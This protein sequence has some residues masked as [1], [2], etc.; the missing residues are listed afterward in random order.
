MRVYTALPGVPGLEGLEGMSREEIL[1]RFGSRSGWL[2]KVADPTKHWQQY[3][4]APIFG[5]CK[6]NSFGEWRDEQGA[7]EGKKAKISLDLTGCCVGPH[8][9]IPSA[10]ELH[11]SF[12]FQGKTPRGQ[13]VY[14]ARDEA[15]RNDWIRTITLQGVLNPPQFGK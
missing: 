7:S 14:L 3:K 8:E 4:D 1:S 5:S 13:H 6:D 2:R 12:M 10:F 9:A 15:D 11:T